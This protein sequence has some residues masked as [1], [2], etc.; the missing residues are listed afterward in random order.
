M[1][2]I[3]SE[4]RRRAA[5]TATG[6]LLAGLLTGCIGLTPAEERQIGANMAREARGQLLFI[7]DAVVQDYVR[8]IGGRLV[9]A[10]GSHEFDY[11]FEVVDDDEI[12]AFAAP[13]GYIYIHTE[14]ILR[15]HNVSELAAVLAHEIGHVALRHISQNYARQRGA[16]TLQQAVVLAASFF[17]F[18][19]LANLGG[20]LAAIAAL[21]Q[22][23][24]AD[25]EAADVFAV[26]ALPRA[27]YDPQGLVS[28]LEVIGQ[29]NGDGHT[30]ALLS[31]HPAT[32]DRIA[33]AVAL[34]AE[35]PPVAGLRRGDR[36][37]LEIIQR[38]IEL[39][40][41]KVTPSGRRPL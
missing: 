15:A 12:N 20:G 39:L 24:R 17:G 19:G 33:V 11:H 40:S 16:S 3:P 5:G 4:G 23:T 10:F 8:D 6:I 18:G 28:F 27:G 21:N 36:G 37:R 35:M 29:E 7:Q 13:A 31:S 26:E 2:P 9:A 14:T 32:R 25:E 22:F 38:R 41:R 1:R 30:P 34:V